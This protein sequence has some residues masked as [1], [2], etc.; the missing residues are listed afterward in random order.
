MLLISVCLV[1]GASAAQ[2][3]KGD[4]N[5]DGLLILARLGDIS[6]G[7]CRCKD[8][9]ELGQSI[10]TQGRTVAQCERKCQQAFSGCTVGEIRSKQRRDLIATPAQVPRQVPTYAARPAQ[11]PDPHRNFAECMREIG[12]AVD[13]GYRMKLQS[14]RSLIKWR[15][16]SEAEM[17]RVNNCVSRKAGT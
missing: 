4:A 2:D 14:G 15:L 10:F 5:G 8:P 11:G 17:M 9:C 13:P 1:Q 7:Q 3:G 12:A 6:N 16:H